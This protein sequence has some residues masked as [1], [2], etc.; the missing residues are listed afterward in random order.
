[1]KKILLLLILGYGQLFA[2]DSESTLKMYHG[3]F[4]ALSSK[5][6]ITVYIKDKEY[7]DVFIHSK[8]IVL[9][10][11]VQGSDIALVTD[12]RTLK[13]ILYTKNRNFA[14][15]PIIFVTNYHFLKM[16]EKIV[17]AFYWRKGR[18]QLLFIKNRL[19]QYNITLPKEY[20]NFMIDE[21]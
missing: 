2:L 15:K 20:Q 11:T 1:M 5:I 7:R 12:E 8:K 18:S 16:S 21:L 14:K 13:D 17:G 6:P 3:I 19:R 4:T 10:N 9:S